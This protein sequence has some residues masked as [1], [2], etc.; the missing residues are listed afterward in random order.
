MESSQ[1]YC[2]NYRRV[3]VR[4]MADIYSLLGSNDLSQDH[5]ICTSK[6]VENY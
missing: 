5:R 3:L 6:Y 4:A 2:D 1:R